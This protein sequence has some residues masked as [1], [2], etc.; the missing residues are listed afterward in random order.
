M[1]MKWAPVCPYVSSPKSLNGF[2]WNS[3]LGAKLNLAVEFNY[4]PYFSNIK[5]TLHEAQI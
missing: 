3:A 2:Q 4:G 1:R 5:P